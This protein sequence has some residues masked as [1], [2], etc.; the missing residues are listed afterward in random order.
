MAGI[1]RGLDAD[2]GRY[3]YLLNI[4]K[5]LHCQFVDNSVLVCLCIGGGGA[6][7]E[8]MGEGGRGGVRMGGWGV[9]V[10]IYSRIPCY[11]GSA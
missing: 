1:N 6:G 11:V 9:A 2:N 4:A 3:K 7:W 8:D 10:D 5:H